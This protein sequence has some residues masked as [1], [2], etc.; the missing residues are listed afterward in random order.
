MTGAMVRT[1]LEHLASRYIYA[2]KMKAA[3]RCLVWLARSRTRP[4]VDRTA[5]PT[6]GATPM[7]IIRMA[8]ASQVNSIISFNLINGYKVITF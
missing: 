3:T 6:S 1:Y 8:P 7:Y 4:E 5:I 2:V